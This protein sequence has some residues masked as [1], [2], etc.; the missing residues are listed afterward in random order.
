MSVLELKQEITRLNKRSREE[1][2]AYLVH[3]AHAAPEWRQVA[4]RRIRGMKKGKGMS[5]LELENRL[6]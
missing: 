4:A 3:L 5:A 1:I 2:Q 6:R